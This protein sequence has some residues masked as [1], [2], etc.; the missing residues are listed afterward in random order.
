MFP[1]ELECGCEPYFLVAKNRTKTLCKAGSTLK[2]RV[3][4]PY[5]L[6]SLRLKEY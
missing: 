6:R 4:Y 3:S 5:T 2:H 1:L